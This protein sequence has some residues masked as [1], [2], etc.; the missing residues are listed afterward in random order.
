MIVAQV[1]EVS[2]EVAV[3]T[4]SN[5]DTRD[6][7]AEADVEVIPIAGISTP[8]VVVSAQDVGKSAVAELHA[9]FYVN[10]VAVTR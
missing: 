8:T 3:N 5:C 1:A 6:S 10:G 9:Q 7:G 4:G 2:I